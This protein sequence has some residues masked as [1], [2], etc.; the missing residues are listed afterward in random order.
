[1]I[2]CGQFRK[3]KKVKY[4]WLIKNGKMLIIKI[5]YFYNFSL[6][7]YQFDKVKLIINC[8]FIIYVE[9][10][11]QMIVEKMVYEKIEIQYCKFLIVYVK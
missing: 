9:I 6:I 1:M 2:K 5:C 4:G 3:K 11:C 7:K 8:S 10:K